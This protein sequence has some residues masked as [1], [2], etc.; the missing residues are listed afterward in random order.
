[1]QEC[2][3]GQL[4][5]WRTPL[6][7]T[8]FW[9]G[10]GHA[11][12]VEN[13]SVGRSSSISVEVCHR[14]ADARP[15]LAKFGPTTVN[16]DQTPMTS[17]TDLVGVGRERAKVGRVRSLGQ[18]RPKFSRCVGRFRSMLINAQH[19]LEFGLVWP[20]VADCGRSPTST[21]TGRS[22]AKF[23]PDLA[24]FRRFGRFGPKRRP[25]STKVASFLNAV[26]A[27]TRRNPPTETP[28]W[29]RVESCRDPTTRPR[30]Q[31]P[32]RSPQPMG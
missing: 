21:G 7:H 14:L 25:A 18:R 26:C 22:L 27:A 31:E 11:A 1:M 12:D 29:R 8:N 9:G 5:S 3:R 13:P 17:P 24:R 4:V 32:L 19:Q 23:G 28:E 6:D 2:Y 30:S 15:N 10:G 20:D 16:T